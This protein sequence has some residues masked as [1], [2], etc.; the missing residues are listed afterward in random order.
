MIVYLFKGSV[1]LITCLAFASRFL[2]LS[3]F[4]EELT[5]YL[6]VF[7]Y[8][9][10][11]VQNSSNLFSACFIFAEHKFSLGGFSIF[12]TFRQASDF[13]LSSKLIYISNFYCSLSIYF[14]K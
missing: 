14:V 1:S 12:I 10:V 9:I 2:S 6:F 4:F 7:S 11:K 8:S 3:F 13:A 5:L